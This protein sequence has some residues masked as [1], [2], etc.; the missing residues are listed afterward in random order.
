MDG[1]NVGYV[2]LFVGF[3]ISSPTRSTSP[4]KTICRAVKRARRA[5]CTT[6][7]GLKTSSRS[8]FTWEP[9]VFAINDGKRSVPT[10]FTPE[11]YGASPADTLYTV[12]GIYTSAD[13]SGAR[14]AR[15]YFRD[16]I[17]RQVLTFTA[18]DPTG[19]PREVITKSGDTF[20]L[21]NKWIDLDANGKPA[22]PVTQK[23][24][25]LTFGDQPFRWRDLDAAAGEYIVGFN[26]QDLDGKPEPVLWP[27]HCAVETFVDTRQ[28]CQSQGA[29]AVRVAK[30]LRVSALP[31]NNLR[32]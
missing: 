20:T 10:L 28:H 13:G 32:G 31:A 17:L 25:T 4:T 18:G 27:G 3:T 22:T 30:A 15:L 24:E 11:T 21:L 2:K 12:E 5:G 8:K 19:S 1:K 14:G 26:V 6:P 29:P 9:I 7:F 16:K 23:G